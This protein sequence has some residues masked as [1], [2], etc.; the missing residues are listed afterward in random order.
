[1]QIFSH[2][3]TEL[4]VHCVSTEK[5]RERTESFNSFE[6]SIKFQRNEFI[7]SNVDLFD[8]HIDII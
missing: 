7:D 4:M 6:N 3:K 8:M 2:V 5:N 1:M